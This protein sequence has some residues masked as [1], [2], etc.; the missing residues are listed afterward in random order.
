MRVVDREGRIWNGRAMAVSRDTSCVGVLDDFI[1]HD[2][3][4][5]Q[6]VESVSTERFPDHPGKHMPVEPHRL[7]A[8]VFTIVT[9]YATR[10]AS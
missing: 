6:E 7:P 4:G 5:A 10:G 9:R 8:L 1:D 3:F 2:T